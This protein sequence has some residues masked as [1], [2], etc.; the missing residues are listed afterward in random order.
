MTATLRDG[1]ADAANRAGW[2]LGPERPLLAPGV[3]HLWLAALDDC[4]GDPVR[5][6][7]AAERARAARIVG[8]RE[9]HRWAHGRAIVRALLARYLQTGP[10]AVDL[11]HGPNGK[12]QLGR[13]LVT[14]GAPRPAWDPEDSEPPLQFNLS[15]SGGTAL[16]AIS[17]DGPVGV[18]VEL[19]GRVRDVVAIAARAL[20]DGAARRLAGLPAHE[21]GQVFLR[22][23][24]RHE[25]RLKCLGAG[26]AGAEG[27]GGRSVWIADVPLDRLPFAD[28][29]AAVAALHPPHAL[30]RWRW[31]GG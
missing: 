11:V 7:S 26:L 1:G 4:D 25:A 9:R 10:A 16:Y 28:G 24:A 5:T 12:P 21:R 18:D 29:A 17:A 6:L 3:I 15:H 31:P 13:P 22:A 30:C 8:E 27:D 14:H 20:G 19:S 2:P 23:W